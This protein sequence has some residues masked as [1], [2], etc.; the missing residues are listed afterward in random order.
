[1]QPGANDNAT[2][3]AVLL[4]LARRLAKDRP[5]RTVVLLATDN[6]EGAIFPMLGGMKGAYWHLDHPYCPA[7][8]IK[9][10]LVLDMLGGR[11]VRGLD[12]QLFLLGG[13]SSPETY[14]LATGLASDP[15]PELPTRAFGV[16]AIEPLGRLVPRGDYDAFR[17]KGIPYLFATSG[18][19][20]EYHTERDTPET[21]DYE[22]LEKAEDSL[23]QVASGL[24][25]KDFKPVYAER[26]AA[27]LDWDRE[28][29]EAESMIGRVLGGQEQAGA[30][31]KAY[32]RLRGVLGTLSAA[33]GLAPAEKAR[34]VRKGFTDAALAIM[35]ANGGVKSGDLFYRDYGP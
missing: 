32:A 12:G 17:R 20:P 24:A 13:E 33:S 19:A 31:A 34:T 27:V 5:D 23:A 10:A 25:A 8:K 11:F 1:L 18:T 14:A 6:E 29:A 15:L 3:V 30:K 21:I 7:D 28:L 35:K 26:E 4:G 2:G 9:A 16:Y 22:F